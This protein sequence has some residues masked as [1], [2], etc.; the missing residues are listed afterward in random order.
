[1]SRGADGLADDA[2]AVANGCS[3]SWNGGI[4]R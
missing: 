3:E 2:E 1:M 4:E